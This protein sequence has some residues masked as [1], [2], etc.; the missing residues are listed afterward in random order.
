[1]SASNTSRETDTYFSCARNHGT[2]QSNAQSDSSTETLVRCSRCTF[3]GPQSV[4]PR[5]TNLQY[6][7]TCSNCTEKLAQEREEKRQA[8]GGDKDKENVR[9]NR[10]GPAIQPVERRPTLLWTNFISLLESH[11]EDAFELDALIDLMGLSI[12]EALSEPMTNHGVATK[13]SEEVWKA[14]GYRYM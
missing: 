9:G 11:K 5:K 8:R 1:M 14:T 12:R 13:I 4:F 3:R 6:L 10:R 7:K 2:N